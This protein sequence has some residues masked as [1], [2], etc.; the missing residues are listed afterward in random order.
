MVIP[1][2]NLNLNLNDAG[3][4]CARASAGGQTCELPF[5]LSLH[6]EKWNSCKMIIPAT[7]AWGIISATCSLLFKHH[8][9]VLTKG[10]LGPPSQNRKGSQC[11]T[12]N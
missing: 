8:V 5:Q 2:Y 9:K 6:K 7:K 3:L 4:Q 10:A 11:K 1:V 12:Q